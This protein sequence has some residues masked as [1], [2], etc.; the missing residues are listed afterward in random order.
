MLGLNIIVKIW[1]A[2]D[3]SDQICPIIRRCTWYK[4]IFINQNK[5]P[6]NLGWVSQKS[7]LINFTSKW[8]NQSWLWNML[9]EKTFCLTTNPRILAKLIKD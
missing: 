7:S 2:N 6:W 8:N 5:K 4:W 3:L 1:K 9:K